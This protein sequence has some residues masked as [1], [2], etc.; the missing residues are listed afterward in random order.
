MGEQRSRGAALLQPVRLPQGQPRLLWEVIVTIS[1]LSL[2]FK[3]YL[4]YILLKDDLHKLYS[5]CRHYCYAYG[6]AIV[7]TKR[8]YLVKKNVCDSTEDKVLPPQY[9]FCLFLTPI[10]DC[11]VA[12]LVQG[13]ALLWRT[14]FH[15][16]PRWNLRG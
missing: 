14:N 11:P 2:R 15:P 16:T 1:L 4:P 12:D 3:M 6:Q 9:Q 8:Q 7:E 13:G 10:M 5:T